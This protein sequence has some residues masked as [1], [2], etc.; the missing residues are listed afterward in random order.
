MKKRRLAP[1]HKAPDFTDTE[2]ALVLLDIRH[3]EQHLP[4]TFV[5]LW[6]FPYGHKLRDDGLQIRVRFWPDGR[7]PINY[8]VHASE[9]N[10]TGYL[11]QRINT[12]E[13]ALCLATVLE[14][15]HE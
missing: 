12:N 10:A 11:T 8:I 13:G 4:Q 1:K 2:M 14:I 9:R 15:L 5:R 3:K 6:R 7:K